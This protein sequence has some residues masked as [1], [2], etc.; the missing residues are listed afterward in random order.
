[1]PMALLETIGSFSRSYQ[2]LLEIIAV[3][4]LLHRS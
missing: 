3:V 2:K 4:N 1:L